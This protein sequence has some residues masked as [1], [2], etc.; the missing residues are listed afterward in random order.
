MNTEHRDIQKILP[1]GE[2][3]RGFVNQRYITKAELNRILKERGIFSLND[4][5][6]YTV[7]LIQTLLLSPKEF[8]KIRDSFSS[9]EDNKKKISRDIKWNSNFD[10]FE[11]KLANVSVEDFLKINL[12]TC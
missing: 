11:P 12:P 5:K 6:E 4:A 8:D 1:F 2:Q 3:L 7:S 10:I 9:R